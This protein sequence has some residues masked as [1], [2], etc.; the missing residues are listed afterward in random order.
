MRNSLWRCTVWGRSQTLPLFDHLTTYVDIFYF[1]NVD[2][3]PKFL[4]TY[5][6]LLVNVV[7]EWHL[8]AFI[9]LLSC[10]I[11][12]LFALLIIFLLNVLLSL[13]VFNLNS[14]FTNIDFTLLVWFTRVMT[15]TSV[16]D[17]LSFVYLLFINPSMTTVSRVFIFL[18]ISTFAHGSVFWMKK[19]KGFM[20]PW[21]S[22]WHAL[23]CLSFFYKPLNDYNFKGIHFCDFFICPWRSL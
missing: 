23:F 11:H 10:A 17:M 1:I 18:V 3:K 4:T 14:I 20:Y 6:P 22:N 2:K 13:Y 21:I 16:I 12:N 15:F 9:R 7:F 19:K 8:Y 5:S